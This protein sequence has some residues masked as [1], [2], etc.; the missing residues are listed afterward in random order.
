MAK[1]FGRL[2]AERR[3]A[4]GFTQKEVASFIG[5]TREN[6]SW[7]ETGRRKEPLGPDQAKRLSRL[8]DL[9]MLTLL[10]AMGYGVECPGF[11]NEEEVALVAA[12]RR[13][14]PA[15]QR[16]LRA[17]AGLPSPQAPYSPGA[18]QLRRIVDR[19]GPREE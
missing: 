5:M 18:Q 1:S 13:L 12:Y 19:L 4:K 14:S 17:A 15:Q 8:L 11:E 10:N 3:R 7:M 6:Y 9:D 16:M 2:L